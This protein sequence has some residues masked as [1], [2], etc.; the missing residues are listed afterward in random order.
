MKKLTCVNPVEETNQRETI[1]AG[2][3]ILAAGKGEMQ[4]RHYE[5]N[6]I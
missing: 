6:I 2:S 4:L 1:R 3:T 5:G